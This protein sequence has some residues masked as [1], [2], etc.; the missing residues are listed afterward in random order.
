M[1]WSLPSEQSTL[2]GPRLELVPYVLED[3]PWIARLAGPIAVARFTGLP[4]PMGEAGATAWIERHLDGTRN[5]VSFGWAA[6]ESGA[7]IGGG[8]IR[9]DAKTGAMSIGFWLGEASWGR[10][11]GTELAR[12]LADHAFGDLDARRVQA[13]CV[14][15]NTASARILEGLGLRPEGRQRGNFERDGRFHDV[16]LFGALADDPRPD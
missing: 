8:S 16:L 7:P 11:L 9:L 2:R 14:A 13:D 3:A 1:T 10:G 4:H 15:E 12:L 6:R 5:G